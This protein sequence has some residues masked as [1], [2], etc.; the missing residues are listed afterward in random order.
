MKTLQI[1]TFLFAVLAAGLLAGCSKGVGPNH[2]EGDEYVVC[3]LT[4]QIEAGYENIPTTYAPGATDPTSADG[5]MANVNRDKYKLRYTFEVWLADGTKKVYRE[6]KVAAIADPAPVF[7]PRLLSVK[8]KMAMWVDFIETSSV[9]TENALGADLYY[10]ADDLRSVKLLKTDFS[11]DAKDAYAATWDADLTKGEFTATVTLRRPLA[12]VRFVA[13]DANEINYS[14]N[15]DYTANIA[16]TPLRPMNFDLL[17]GAVSETVNNAA[18]KRPLYDDYKPGDGT[19]K[20]QT[21]A[22]DYVFVPAAGCTYQVAMQV[23]NPAG[24]SVDLP[25]ATDFSATTKLI[26]DVELK[27]N[28]LTTAV[29]NYFSA[30]SLD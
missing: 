27:P 13:L 19:D 10:N 26:N 6:V 23:F 24:E 17:S 14:D 21:L 15:G 20:S 29:G 4:P 2:N 3:T 5:G 28:T 1:R 18:D 30:F 8:Y 22:W 9:T 11:D 7:A 12:K 25:S 16:F